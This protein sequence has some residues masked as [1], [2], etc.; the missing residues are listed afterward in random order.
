MRK[1]KVLEKRGAPKDEQMFLHGK[2]LSEKNEALS[3]SHFTLEQVVSKVLYGVL[4]R[5]PSM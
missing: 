5:A 2:W 4:M 3:A 1:P